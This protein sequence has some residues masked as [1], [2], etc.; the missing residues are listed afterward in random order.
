MRE[1][2]ETVVSYAFLYFW[3]KFMVQIP[4]DGDFKSG[5]SSVLQARSWSSWSFVRQKKFAGKFPFLGS[6][7]EH[8]AA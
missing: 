7:R 2:S 5:K 3:N 1:V 8:P 6:A 4:W